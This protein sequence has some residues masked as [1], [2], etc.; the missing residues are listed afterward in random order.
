MIDWYCDSCNSYLNDQTGFTDNKRL[1]ACDD[2]G[3]INELTKENIF[4]SKA[5]YENSKADKCI[6]CQQNLA[7][8]V[9][10]EEWEDGDNSSA[11]VTCRHCGCYNFK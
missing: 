10:T 3:Y 7:G 6:S 5:D 11:Y 8:S 2:C 1:W 4:N 9:R